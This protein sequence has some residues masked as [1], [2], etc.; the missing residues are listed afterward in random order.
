M[1]GISAAVAKRSPLLTPS[2]R[3]WPALTACSRMSASVERDRSAGS[4]FVFDDDLLA[5]DFGQAAGDDAT[6]RVHAAPR[7]KPNQKSH[8]TGG[9]ILCPSDTRAGR[10]RGRTHGEMQK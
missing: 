4:R 6:G 3:T 9:P 7:R 8:K 2:A 1:V 10:Q 5:P